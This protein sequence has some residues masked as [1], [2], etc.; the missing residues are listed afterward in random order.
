VGEGLTLHITNGD[1]AVAVLAQVVKGEILPWRD[2]LHEGPV[3]PGL[4]LEELSR[5]RAAF[6][7]Q[8]GWAPLAAAAKAFR[9]RDETLKGAA[10]HEE[11]VLWFEHDLYDQLQLI[12]VLDWFAA[13]PHPRVSLVCEAEYL[14]SMKPARAAQLFAGRTRVE[15]CAV[16]EAKHAW[17]AFRASDPTTIQQ[18]KPKALGFLEAALR[19]QLEE[20]PWLADGLSRTERAV[21]DALRAR[22]LKFDELFVAIR[23]E[24][25]FLGD[26]VLAWHLARMQQE[27]LMEER[28]GQWLAVSRGRTKRLP[29]WLGG[30]RVDADSPWRWDPARGALCLPR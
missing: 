23:E 28:R 27:G 22:P 14:G 18:V 8:C 25:A 4:S 2:V 11:V 26:T 10:G 15:A 21:L 9:E 7:A 3:P 16:G 12:Q 30:V 24:P 6:I 20:F 13:H 29:R 1:S 5:Q 17:A 19:R